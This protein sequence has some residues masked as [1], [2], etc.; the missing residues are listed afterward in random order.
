MPTQLF[1]IGY[2]G[3]NIDDFLNHL[4]SNNID[5]VLDVRQ[6]PLSRKRGFSKTSLGQTLRQADI[7]YVHIPKL[8][9]PKPLRNDLKLTHDY[10]VFFSAMD[11]Y[12]QT[13]T[14]ALETAYSHVIDKTCCLM[15]FERLPAI[16]H[17]NLVAQKIKDRD[18]NGLQ[19]KH[20]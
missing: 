6:L 15:C 19:I 14:Q 11:R 3:Y 8:G 20:V 9:S 12:L 2:E 1:T 5:C 4:I 17:R 16:C 13:Q 10:A 7:D 18:G